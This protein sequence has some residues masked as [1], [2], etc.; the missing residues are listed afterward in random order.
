MFGDVC[1]L[2]NLTCDNMPA[3]PKYFA[4]PLPSMY[5]YLGGKFE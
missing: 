2:L 1:H 5:L 4:G 3:P